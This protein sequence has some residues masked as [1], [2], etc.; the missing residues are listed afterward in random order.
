MCGGLLR[1]TGT[2]ICR[3]QEAKTCAIPYGDLPL[4]SIYAVERRDR[5]LADVHASEQVGS[6]VVFIHRGRRFL[7]VC[8]TLAVDHEEAVCV[9]FKNVAEAKYMLKLIV[10]PS[11]QWDERFCSN[12]IDFLHK[13]HF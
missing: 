9:H 10:C 8:A 3:V 4:R 13:L 12:G 1:D 6:R 2:W 11:C 7:C 5:E